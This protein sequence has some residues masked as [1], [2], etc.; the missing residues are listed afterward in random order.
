M[1]KEFRNFITR[2]NV[3]DLAVAVIMGGAFSK[4]VDSLVKD[5]ITP[6]LLNPAM[7][8][9]KAENLEK[10]TWNGIS[11]G[12][13]LAAVLN[14][15]VISFVI[16]MLIKAINKAQTVFERKKEEAAAAAPAA[17]PEDIALLTEIRDLLKEKS[18]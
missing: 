3:I 17:P 7:T 15:L 18:R 9:A 11:Y 14:F 2:G 16:F 4:I 1:L 8:A 5:I 10:L 12:V 6:S 13:F